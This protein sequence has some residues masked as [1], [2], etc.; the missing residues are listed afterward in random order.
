MKCAKRES[1]YLTDECRKIG[2]PDDSKFTNVGYHAEAS[3]R[4]RTM[5]LPIAESN[6]GYCWR[7]PSEIEWNCL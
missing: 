3:G 2:Q 6:N 1:G 5:F 4:D 7:G